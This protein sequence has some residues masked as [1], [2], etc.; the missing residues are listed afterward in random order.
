[1]RRPEIPTVTSPHA[2]ETA[3]RQALNG[4]RFYPDLSGMLGGAIAVVGALLYLF[5][6][7]TTSPTPSW[8][9]GVNERVEDERVEEC[10]ARVAAWRER[11][12]VAI[13]LSAGAVRWF[14]SRRKRRCHARGRSGGFGT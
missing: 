11:D 10:K 14:R 13:R 5:N 12:A 9:A 4:G 1:M 8:P 7:T 3:A 6:G 2:G